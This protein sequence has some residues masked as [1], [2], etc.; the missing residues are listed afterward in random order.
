MTWSNTIRAAVSGL[1]SLYPAILSPLNGEGGN[2][3]EMADGL[4]RFSTAIDSLRSVSWHSNELTIAGTSIQ[5]TG[6]T[7]HTWQ[8]VS[9]SVVVDGVSCRIPYWETIAA[10]SPANV[11]LID[12]PHPRLANCYLSGYTINSRSPGA[13]GS[14]PLSADRFK[15]ALIEY[16]TDAMYLYRSDDAADTTSA[17]AYD[18]NQDFRITIA[19]GLRPQLNQHRYALALRAETGGLAVLGRQVRGVLFHFSKVA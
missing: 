2:Q 13:H 18:A 7:A 1:T 4:G 6:E 9:Q 15:A 16:R 12:V 5:V 11:L 17:A 19:S 3:A 14:I 8:R 10:S